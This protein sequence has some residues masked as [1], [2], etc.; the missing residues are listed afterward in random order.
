MKQ[1]NST[2]NIV[3]YC[4]RVKT[5]YFGFLFHSVFVCQYIMLDNLQEMA[6]VQS[7]QDTLKEYASRHNNWRVLDIQFD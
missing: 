3:L 6:L 1:Q 2:M 5:R 4:Y 7:I